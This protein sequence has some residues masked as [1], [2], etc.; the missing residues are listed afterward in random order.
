M[1]ELFL[2]YNIKELHISLTHGLW[3]HEVWGYPTVEA[4]PGAEIWAWF[5][6]NDTDS[7][8]DKQW[9]NLCSTL[10]G[11]LCASLSFIDN[12]NTLT[13]NYLFRPQFNFNK[14]I[15][16]T[17]IRY[18]TLPH[19][20]VCKENLTPWKKLL[21]CSVTEGFV[22]L[23]N[24]DQIYS[25][26]YHSIGIHLTSSCLKNDCSRSKI[27]IKQ[28][29][30]VV[31]DP[32]I[33][34][35]RDW[36]IRKLFGQGLNGACPLAESSKIFLDVTNTKYELS[37]NP[38][39]EFISKRGGN[40]LRI[41]EFNI[42][43]TS[44]NRM[45][46]LA[47][48][49]LNER[50]VK[51]VTPPPLYAKRY[52]LGIG[53]ERGKIVT[54]ITNNHWAPLN[55]IIQ[56]NIPWFVPI[57][58]HSLVIKNGLNKIESNILKY[59]PGQQRTRPYQLEVGFTIPARSNVEFSFDFDYIFLKW[60]EY[61]PDANHG[62]YIGSSV[63]TT[64]LPVAR[65]YTSIP[66]DGMLFYSNF[67]NTNKNGY[68]IEIR[69]ENLLITLPTPDFSMPYNVICLACTVVALAFGPIH[70]MSTKRLVIQKQDIPL[71]LFGKIK[72]KLFR[73][74]NVGKEDEQTEIKT[75]DKKID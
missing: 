49:N 71:T 14:N 21:P 7:S 30:N 11:L 75:K 55:V 15:N 42:K 68:L 51:L 48:V 32:E 62:H 50:N 31:F 41:A 16:S 22:S 3:R 72:Q 66:I 64:V 27:N 40:E 18:G 38:S 44:P 6:T 45:F 17:Y 43:E 1:A 69:T 9:K 33:T 70:N 20:I 19:E 23:L 24:S 60:L 4:P 26:N 74:T 63:I 37:P 67:N 65:N 39:R 28:T 29:L 59:T 13:P 47:V 57:Y 53:Q 10:S 35:G 34:G 2:H 46:N 12:T 8:V 36:S 58:L 5:N 61:P 73:K 52:I 54:K 25:T 56:E